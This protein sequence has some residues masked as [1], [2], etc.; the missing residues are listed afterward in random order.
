MRFRDWPFALFLLLTAAQAKAGF[1]GGVDTFNGTVLDSTTWA[2][3]TGN[4]G[5]TFSQN[6]ALTIQSNVFVADGFLTAYGGYTTKQ[7]LVPVGG[8]AWVE[9]KVNASLSVANTFNLSRL[10]LTTD[11]SGV[12]RTGAFTASTEVRLDATFTPLSG[13][14]V[15]AGADDYLNGFGTSYGGGNLKP[16]QL[17]LGS[18]YIFQIERLT[19]A[20]TRLSLFQET[21]P[22]S[23]GNTFISLLGTTTESSVSSALPMYVF[24]EAIGTST[25]FDRVT[26]NQPLALSQTLLPPAPVPEASTLA[27][28][29]FGTLSLMRRCRRS[30]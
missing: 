12:P 8:S 5:T 11:P 27:I 9:V 13:G 14:S 26:L 4:T 10:H 1:L 22:A 29:G 20:S 3:S 15:N 28:L 7:P 17:L 18:T 19:S 30:K 24:L 16:S 6:N 23:G 25:T 21:G 2:T